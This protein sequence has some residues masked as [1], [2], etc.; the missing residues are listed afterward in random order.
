MLKR[1]ILLLS[2]IA[3]IVAAAP[4]AEACFRCKFTIE[5]AYC[6]P[7]TWGRTDCI[8]DDF[9][10]CQVYGGS[11]SQGSPDPTALAADYQV[12]AVERIE[13]PAPDE[14]LV[15]KLDA[16]RPAAQSVR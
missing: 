13:A 8:D 6:I 7:T 5:G 1:M 3:I 9:G 16:S 11:C 10:Y 4:S 2:A 12:V 14:A 15:A